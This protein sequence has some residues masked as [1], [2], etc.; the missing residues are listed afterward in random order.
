MDACENIPRIEVRRRVLCIF[1][2]ILAVSGVLAALSCRFIPSA[3]SDTSVLPKYSGTDC[4]VIAEVIYDAAPTLVCLILLLFASG[5]AAL[6][7]LGG[8]MCALESSIVA[9]ALPVATAGAPEAIQVAFA[10]LSPVIL[11]SFT[12]VLAAKSD[13]AGVLWRILLLFFFGGIAVAAKVLLAITL[14]II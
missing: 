12:A 10:A 9:V 7:I 14:R 2:A 1:S 3:L 11:A 5:T 6:P 4:G 13:K 8:A